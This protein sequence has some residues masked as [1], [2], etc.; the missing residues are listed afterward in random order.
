MPGHVG[1]GILQAGAISS[2]PSAFY[3]FNLKRLL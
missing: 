1:L 3:F 2:F